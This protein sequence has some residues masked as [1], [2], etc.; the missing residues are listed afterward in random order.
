[1]AALP[2]PNPTDTSQWAKDLL[3]TLGD[4]L[5]ASNV[6]YITAWEHG[7]S[8]SGFGYNPLGTEQSAPGSVHAPGNSATVQAFRSWSSGL[9]ATDQTFTGYSGNT[10]LL[11]ALKMGNATLA[12]LSSAQTQGSWA[13]GGESSISALGTPQAFTY[14]GA[15]GLQYGAPG[16]AS[17]PGDTAP[18]VSS[19]SSSPGL[20][21]QTLHILNPLG[22]NFL[23]QGTLKNTTALQPAKVATD[24]TSALSKSI[25]GPLVGWIENGAAD[26]TFVGF[27]LMLVVIGLVVTFKGGSQI[28]LQAPASPSGG[29]KETG[30]AVK[31]AAVAA[32]A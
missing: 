15:Q 22:T 31:D 28:N 19:S 1:V 3:T 12:Q 2:Y 14:G 20:L 23:G 10:A 29:V 8:P 32:A 25:F 7:E 13:T 16:I 26:V 18:G 24:V 21:S 17:V 11:Q 27:G 9:S 6:G 5:T 30:G 4:P